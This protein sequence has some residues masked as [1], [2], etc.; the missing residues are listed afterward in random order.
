MPSL[1]RTLY[2]AAGCLQS[3]LDGLYTV[4]AVLLDKG[5]P[6]LTRASFAF[7]MNSLLPM[8]EARTRLAMYTLHT[9]LVTIC[10][11]IHQLHAH[12]LS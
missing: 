1:I 10:A 5:K 11:S 9:I 12:K 8:S 2:F 4:L 3:V 6:H 7:T